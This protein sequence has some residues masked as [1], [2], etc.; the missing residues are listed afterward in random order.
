MWQRQILACIA[1]N[2][3]EIVIRP[4]TKENTIKRHF[5]TVHTKKERGRPKK[6]NKNQQNTRKNHNKVPRRIP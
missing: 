1:R 5:R 4:A 6:R 2:D 3:P